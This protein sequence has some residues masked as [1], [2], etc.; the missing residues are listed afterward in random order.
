MV[1]LAASSDGVVDFSEDLV[2]LFEV[3]PL[4]PFE[5]FPPYP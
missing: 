5:V 2:E 4:E 1:D 3:V